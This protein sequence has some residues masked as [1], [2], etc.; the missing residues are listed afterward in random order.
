VEIDIDRFEVVK[1]MWKLLVQERLSLS[2]I[3]DIA[4]EEWGFR[5][6]QKKRMGG[7]KLSVSSLYNVFT[8]PF[9]TGKIRFKGELMD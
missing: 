3:V 8:N 1:R 7:K 5:T 2:K 9:Y 4:N 6:I